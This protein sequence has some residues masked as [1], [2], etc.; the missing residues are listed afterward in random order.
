MLITLQWR[1]NWGKNGWKTFDGHEVK[2]QDIIKLLLDVE[3]QLRYVGTVDFVY[4]PREENLLADKYCNEAV[5][6][7]EASRG[8]SG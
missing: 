1:Y 5:D 4:V 8:I 7:E 6:A 3:E 2:N